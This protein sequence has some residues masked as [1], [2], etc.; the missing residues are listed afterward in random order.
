MKSFGRCGEVSVFVGEAACRGRG[1]S[2]RGAIGRWRNRVVG[3]N[4]VFRLLR[5]SK[6][7]W[8]HSDKV[9]RC[10]F[11]RFCHCVVG[12]SGDVVGS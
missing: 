3:R 10:R 7:R 12:R 1:G 9:W 6:V 2:V 8:S 5:L 4:K 11:V